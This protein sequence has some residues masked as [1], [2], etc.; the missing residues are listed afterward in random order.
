M[1]EKVIFMRKKLIL[2]LTVIMILAL[3]VCMP[4]CGKKDAGDQAAD[5]GAATE[6]G[7]GTEEPARTVVKTIEGIDEDENEIPMMIDTIVLYD[8]GTVEVFPTDDLK[9]NELKDT[10]AES[11]FPFEESGKVKDV[12]VLY[13]GNGGYRTIAALME[14]G[15]ISIVNGGA[16]IED[17]IIAVMD[18]VAGRDNFVSIENVADE[19]A[20]V[21]V[22]TT[23]DGEEIIL[24]YSF[25]F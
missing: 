23:E 19:S 22:G 17:H 14:D 21:M 25:N 24:D 10:D 12:Q 11:L 13:Y 5:A 9:K 8:D 7:E 6:Q 3:A 20:V 4:S 2:L 18:N 15:S 1:K 16:L